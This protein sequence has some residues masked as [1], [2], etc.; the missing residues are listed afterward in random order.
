MRA[1]FLDGGIGRRWLSTEQAGARVGMSSTW[2]RKQIDSGR[3]RAIVFN[4]GL[5]KTYRIR[6]EDWLAFLARFTR[7][8]GE[9]EED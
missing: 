2:V 8:M 6:P 3:L 4:T 5:R 9:D 1:R 7:P